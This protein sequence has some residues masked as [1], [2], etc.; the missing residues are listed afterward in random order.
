MTWRRVVVAVAVAVVA[1][2]VLFDSLGSDRETAERIA[3]LESQYGRLEGSYESLRSAAA[4]VGVEAPSAS[5]A[6][7]DDAAPVRIVGDEGP[8]G[9]RGPR[10][11]QGPPGEPGASGPEGADGATGSAGAAGPAGA[12]GAAGSDGQP[13]ED[14]TAGAQGPAGEPGADGATG[15]AGPQG[16]PGP[17]GPAGP[18][19]AVGPMPA[20]IVIDGQTCTDPDGDGTY[21]CG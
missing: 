21:V 8:P 18:Q 17:V 11:A 19:G 16:E 1:T 3:V 7:G 4:S 10:G 6:A 2:L 12:D 5:E 13:G 9:E 14:G 20:A 15:P